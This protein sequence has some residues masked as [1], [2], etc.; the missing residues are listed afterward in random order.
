MI[1]VDK[2]LLLQ[3]KVE[4]AIQKI[5]RLRAEN[6]ALRTQCSE[7]TNALSAKTELLSNFM[8]EG[9]KVED[10]ILSALSRL[11][12]VEN[13]LLD[14][15]EKLEEPANDANIPAVD[16]EV[17]STEQSTQE[18]T[19]EQNATP[20]DNGGEAVAE[21]GQENAPEAGQPEQGNSEGYTENPENAYNEQNV[22]WQ[23][24]SPE[25]PDVP[26][27][28]QQMP[29]GEYAPENQNPEQGLEFG[30]N[31]NDNNSLFGNTEFATENEGQN[32][33]E[34]IY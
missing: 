12:S 2:I 25:N 9:K 22:E 32:P 17:N 31:S 26:A 34:E 28:A 11:D 18:N 27:D 30:A 6:D 7:L 3:K 8:E 14:N 29:N 15:A 20:N 21:F 1:S 5:E 16:G 10:G 33:P 19:D 4:S 24:N 13:F 23:Q